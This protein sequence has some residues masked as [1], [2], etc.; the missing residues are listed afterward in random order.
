MYG[1][2]SARDVRIQTRTQWDYQPGQGPH[3]PFRDQQICAN[4][5]KVEEPL[6]PPP[7]QEGDWKNPPSAESMVPPEPPKIEPKTETAFD[8]GLQASYFDYKETDNNPTLKNSG[9]QY[10]IG[11]AY[12]GALGSNWFTRFE[13][14]ADGGMLKF[15]KYPVSKDVPNYLGEVRAA[16][17]WD[18][19]SD[20]FGI[21]P[22][23]G[24]GYR[25]L[26]TNLKAETNGDL[27]NVKR[28]GQYLFAP[29]G[30]QPRF[31]LENGHKLVLTAEYDPIIRGWQKDYLSQISESYADIQ[32][33]QKKGY[34]LRGEISYETE[35]FVVGPFFNYWNLRQSSTDCGTGS[36][37]TPIETCDFVPHNRTIEY[38]L[39]VRYRFY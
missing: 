26:Q 2:F 23:I 18:L 8:I 31:R 25:F 27:R 37:A 13:G 17:G 5:P 34:G 35:R 28:Q 32:H 22:Y 24:I 15:E 38:G 7:I 14:R 33:K 4:C 12:T 36:G 16:I 29:I 21:S 19:L 39:N 9:A 30:L 11:M 6:P 1:K 20:H 10:G 3:K